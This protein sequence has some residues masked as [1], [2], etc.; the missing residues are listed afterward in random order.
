MT[1]QHRPDIETL[2]AVC[3]S[4]GALDDAHFEVLEVCEYALEL[5]ARVTKRSKGLPFFTP[6]F[7]AGIIVAIGLFLFH[8]L[9]SF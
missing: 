2:A 7:M 4:G 8:L 5:E 1:K 3:H 6:M 9:R